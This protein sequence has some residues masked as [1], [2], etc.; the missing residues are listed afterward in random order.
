MVIRRGGPAIIMIMAYTTSLLPSLALSLDEEHFRKCQDTAFCRRHRTIPPKS[1]ANAHA[2]LDT[3]VVHDTVTFDPAQ[4]LLSARL[5]NEAVG[6]VLQLQLW[7]YRGF[8]FRLR[9]TEQP[10]S[11]GPG[12]AAERGAGSG[13]PTCGWE[14]RPLYERYDAV[15]ALHRHEHLASD[16]GQLGCTLAD[17]TDEAEPSSAHGKH[18]LLA[19]D[20]YSLIIETTPFKIS[21]I[22]KSFSEGPSMLINARGTLHYEPYE[23]QDGSSGVQNATRMAEYGMNTAGVW[24]P[25]AFDGHV[26]TARR[27]PASVGM[28]VQFGGAAQMYGV[29]ERAAGFPLQVTKDLNGHFVAEPYRLFNMDVFEYTTDNSMPLYGAIPFVMAVNEHGAR[30]VLWLNAAETYLDVIGDAATNR[31]AHTHWISE[32]GNIDM[33]LFGGPSPKQVLDQYTAISGRP[34]L[35][36]LFALGYHQSRWNYNDEADVTGLVG[37]FDKHDIPVDVIW[38]DIEHTD[39][40]KYMT[41]DTT[42]F[43]QPEAMIEK[44]AA[45]GRKLVTVIDPHLKAADDYGLYSNARD[46]G[47]L[48]KN[49]SSPSE[50]Y[51]GD[52][53]PGKSSWLDFTNPAAREYWASQWALPEG[54]GFAGVGSLYTWNDMNEPSVFDGPELSMDKSALHHGG[55]EHREMHN[56]YGHLMTQATFDGHRRARPGERPFVLSRAFFAGSQRHVAVWTGDNTADWGHLAAVVPMLLSLGMAGLPFVGADIGGFFGEPSAELLIRW[57]ETSVYTPFC[58]AHAHLDTGRREPWLYGPEV[59]GLVRAAVKRRYTLLPYLYT[60]FDESHR[61]GSPIVRPRWLEFPADPSGY[62]DTSS[63][64][65]GPAL[66]VFPITQP[67]VR[68]VD[69][70]LPPGSVWHEVSSLRWDR[71]APPLSG[72]VQ[73]QAPL[74]TT[75][76]LLQQ[77]SVVPIRERERRASAQMAGDPVTLLV[78]TGKGEPAA[79]GWLYSDDGATDEH[80][81]GRYRRTFYELEHSPSGQL[82]LTSWTHALPS[83]PLPAVSATAARSPPIDDAAPAWPDL[84]AVVGRVMLFGLSFCPT[85]AELALISPPGAPPADGPMEVEVVHCEPAGPGAFTATLRPQAQATRAH[86]DWR[87]TVGG[88]FGGFEEAATTR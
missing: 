17:N 45:T 86:G 73:L 12:C 47:L 2:D 37:S 27:G 43:P 21:V 1:S 72:H 33:F 40:K 66:L 88:G 58:R 70:E 44:L 25:E 68:T 82:I 19:C 22:D 56:I 15:E 11:P 67:S 74:G 31:P 76:L 28:D 20:A 4:S 18:L 53:W 80:E 39:S 38:L 79:S 54:E 32:T 50:P 77:G 46:A 16:H 57:Y 60:L 69:A 48:V 36:P 55:V 78:A 42:S 3:V 14:K 29:P 51:E 87:I 24:D 34:Q 75:P 85:K 61:A 35:P 13:E 5:M 81:R 8:T 65:L 84:D 30:G 23:R 26:D 83:H 59:A 41:W 64:M 63:F 10:V 71:P 62:A 9:I 49:M 7:V 52:C 6:S